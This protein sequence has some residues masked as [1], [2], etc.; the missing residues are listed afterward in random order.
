MAANQIRNTS[1]LPGGPGCPLGHLGHICISVD[2]QYVAGL[3]L[4]P[5]GYGK[6]QSVRKIHIGVMAGWDVELPR[7]VLGLAQIANGRV[8][9]TAKTA[10]IPN[11]TELYATMT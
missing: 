5:I 4:V 9:V 8:T 2:S 1:R 7:Y 3:P 10:A 6:M 11:A